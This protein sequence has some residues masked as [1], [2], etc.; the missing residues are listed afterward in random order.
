[1]ISKMFKCFVPFL[2][3]IVVVALQIANA[4]ECGNGIISDSLMIKAFSEDECL[5]QSNSSH[6]YKAISNSSG[7]C[8]LARGK[9]YVLIYGV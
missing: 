7:L 9:I 8:Y 5:S 1:M 2:Q 6:C 4:F 3:I